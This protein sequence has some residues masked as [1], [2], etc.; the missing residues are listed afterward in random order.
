MSL[1][2][3]M[4]HPNTPTSLRNQRNIME[5]MGH[6]YRPESRTCPFT[7]LVEHTI[8]LS[9]HAH[10]HAHTHTNTHTHIWQILFTL[11]LSH[12]HTNIHVY[13]RDL[14]VSWF[15]LSLTHTHKHT[16]VP[17]GFVCVFSWFVYMC[18]F[19]CVCVY[20]PTK[21]GLADVVVCVCV[22]VCK[23]CCAWRDSFVSATNIYLFCNHF[24][25]THN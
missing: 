24:S 12:T 25:L 21:S 10:T 6:L 18:T 1:T 14:R 8:D 3:S 17:T 20:A 22:C 5:L 16:C 9:T 23:C 4:S 15:S 13:I 19:E 2:N 11:S 7:R